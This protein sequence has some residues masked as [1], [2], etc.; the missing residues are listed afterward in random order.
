MIVPPG[1][2]GGMVRG[3]AVPASGLAEQDLQRD[4]TGVPSDG[5]LRQTAGGA[6]GQK[7]SCR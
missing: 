2:E 4:G 3:R 5:L 1:P 6:A 7:A